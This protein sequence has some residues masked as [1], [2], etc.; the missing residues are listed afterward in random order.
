[1]MPTADAAPARTVSQASMSAKHT[2]PEDPRHVALAAA[3]RRFS[4]AA[5]AA[6]AGDP[7]APEMA[8]AAYAEVLA[9]MAS[10]RSANAPPDAA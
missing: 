10:L 4:G 6:L 2:P 7:A 5:R 8:K 3:K 1:M 9:V